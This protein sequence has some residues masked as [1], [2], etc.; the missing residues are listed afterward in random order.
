MT[1][2]DEL[3]RGGSAQFAVSLYVLRLL[4]LLSNTIS[5]VETQRN[6]WPRCRG[7]V[8]EQVQRVVFIGVGASTEVLDSVGTPSV[9]AGL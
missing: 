7:A 4:D 2:G 6:Q 1:R 5:R 3:R 8:S 9:T